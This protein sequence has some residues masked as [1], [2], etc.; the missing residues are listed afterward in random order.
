MH[1]Y[2]AEQRAGGSRVRR[3]ALSL[4]LPA[5]AA[6]ALMASPAVHGQ[7][8]GEGG[9]Y[10]SLTEATLAL[11]RDLAREYARGLQLIST[12]HVQD[13]TRRWEGS[14]SL[15][16]RNQATVYPMG[17]DGVMLEMTFRY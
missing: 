17:D 7:A 8:G 16:P 15:R 5:I 10:A 9:H 3:R 4:V 6:V 11:N 2:R 1:D 13:N 12:G 14:A